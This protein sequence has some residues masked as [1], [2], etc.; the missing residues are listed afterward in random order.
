[1]ERNHGRAR[2]VKWL[3]ARRRPPRAA[4]AKRIA[5]MLNMGFLCVRRDAG[6][7]NIAYNGTLSN[8]LVGFKFGF[9]E[10]VLGGNCGERGMKNWSGGR[11]GRREKAKERGTGKEG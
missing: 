8:Y 7:R 10:W 5:A 11:A 9:L 4:T 6:M 3:K 1:M 2:P